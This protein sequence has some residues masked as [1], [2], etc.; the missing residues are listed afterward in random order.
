MG[1][2]NVKGKGDDGLWTEIVRKSYIQT[3]FRTY[4]MDNHNQQLF[5]AEIYFEIAKEYRTYIKYD[6]FFFENQVEI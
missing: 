6:Y 4:K 2:R 5:K 3:V 1:S